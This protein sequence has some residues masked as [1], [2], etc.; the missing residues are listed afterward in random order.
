MK[1]EFQALTGE[2]ERTE[3]QQEVMLL[4]CITNFIFNRKHK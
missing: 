2:E 1:N 4:V 3:K